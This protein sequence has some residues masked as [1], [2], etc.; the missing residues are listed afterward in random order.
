MNLIAT[1][2]DL[3]A[4]GMGNTATMIEVTEAEALLISEYQALSNMLMFTLK[5]DGS[6]PDEVRA[7]LFD[8]KIDIQGKL[9][10]GP[11][12]NKYYTRTTW[13]VA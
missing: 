1:S 2:G 9:L 4:T 3:S 12:K 10:D 13:S 6:Y 8:R 7:T 11:F 5:E